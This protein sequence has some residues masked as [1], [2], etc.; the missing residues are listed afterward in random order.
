MMS[1]LDA[2]TTEDK[3]S[4]RQTVVDEL[5]AFIE[6]SHGQ[7]DALLAE[8]KWTKEELMDL[9]RN[10]HLGRK[11]IILLFSITGISK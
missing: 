2:A 8:L 5:S 7:L 11:K 1:S 3:L 4:S 9:V 6:T 10:L